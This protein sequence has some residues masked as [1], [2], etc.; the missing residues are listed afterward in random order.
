MS[1]SRLLPPKASQTWV[2]STPAA[3]QKDAGQTSEDDDTTVEG[4]FREVND[5]DAE[6]PE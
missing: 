4:E 1:S 3:T 6:K 2:D 5:D